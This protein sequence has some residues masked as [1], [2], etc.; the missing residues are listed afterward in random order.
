M[1]TTQIDSVHAPNK[2][3]DVLLPV[4]IVTA[5]NE[6]DSLARKSPVGVRQ[7]ERPQEI[8]GHFEHGPHGEDLVDKILCALDPELAQ[9]VLNH[10]IAGQCN[11]LLL[12][13]AVSTFVDELTD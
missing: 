11:A 4:A 2:L 8:V 1:Q 5:L 10:L 12:N 6:V 9:R 3:V 7:L 13:L